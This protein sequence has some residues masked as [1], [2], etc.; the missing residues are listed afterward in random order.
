MGETAESLSALCNRVIRAS[1]WLV[2]LSERQHGD[3]RPV[4]PVEQTL[5]L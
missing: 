5:L 3:R 4:L 2:C 1:R